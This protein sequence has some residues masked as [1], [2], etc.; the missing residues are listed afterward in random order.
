MALSMR[1]M[2]RLEE[3]YVNEEH[4]TISSELDDFDM[5]ERLS[6]AY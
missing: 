5:R 6:N 2:P 4:V 1:I 3:D